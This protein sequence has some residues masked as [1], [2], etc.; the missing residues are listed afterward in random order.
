MVVGENARSDDMDVN[1][2]RE[3]QKTNIRAA[4]ADDAIKLVPPLIMSLEQALEFVSHDEL[5]ELTPSSIRL[6]KRFLD[7]NSRRREAKKKG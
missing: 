6:R 2:T 7:Q 5:V 3:K 1:P 4:M